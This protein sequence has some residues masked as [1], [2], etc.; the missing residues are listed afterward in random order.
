VT[1]DGIIGLALSGG[2]F[3]A[4]AFHLGVLKRLREL[5]ILPRV[6]VV[7]TV[8]GGSIAGA[9]W[10]YWQSLRGE[11]LSEEKAWQ[12]FEY[13]LLVAMARDVRGRAMLF[14][15][16]LPAIV[17]LLAAAGILWI[18]GF[19]P[20]RVGIAL[21]S[22]FIGASLAWHYLATTVL[23]IL[24]RVMLFDETPVGAL[25]PLRFEHLPLLMINASA[26]NG[27]EHVVFASRQPDTSY[28]GMF[29]AIVQRTSSRYALRRGRPA[30]PM[31]AET[32]LARAVAASSAVPGIFA[33]LI[34]RDVLKQV[35]GFF[36]RPLWGA[37]GGTGTFTVVDGGV[38]DNQGT[39][40]LGD[41]CHHL[42]VSDG[43][44][45]L[46]SDLNP[47]TWGVIFRAQDI[48]YERVRD[49]GYMRLEDRRQLCDVLAEHLTAEQLEEYERTN[50]PLLRS[51]SYV[52][53]YPSERFGWTA[54]QRLPE[55]L[56]PLIASIR[57]DLDQFSRTEISALMFHGYTMIDHGLR[58]YQPN[59][60]PDEMPPLA[61]TFLG[62]G[63]FA[64]WSN[65]AEEE[66]ERAA[67]HLSVSGSRLGIVRRLSRWW[68][69][70]T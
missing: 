25:D 67:K 23:E 17:L 7:S 57:T 66:I 46:R 69:K 19:T 33:P 52:E 59:L 5:G 9:N 40:L 48:I 1:G 44:A 64:D 18:A 47:S 60:L 65:P 61:F 63:L 55:K 11:K 49:L 58:A 4:A 20:W 15:F 32:T 22:V 14:A 10:T 39:N 38:F 3:R 41:I 45:A 42:I 27:G 51:Y 30:V 24:Y 34:F 37:G 56:L 6:R 35:V 68:S 70:S 36:R 28:A 2:G 62:P 43:S 31:P 12:M 26:L 50:G 53:L 21:L 54:G 13:S 29:S 8:S 16:V